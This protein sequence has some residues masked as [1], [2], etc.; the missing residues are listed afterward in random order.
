MFWVANTHKSSK[1]GFLSTFPALKLHTFKFSMSKSIPEVIKDNKTLMY[2]LL[3]GG[4]FIDI[5]SRG[6]SQF[7]A[8]GEVKKIPFFVFVHRPF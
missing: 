2:F 7:E 6:I 3:K 4:S 5:Q 8:L 1:F